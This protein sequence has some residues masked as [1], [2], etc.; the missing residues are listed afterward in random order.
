MC[1]RCF[2]KKKVSACCQTERSFILWQLPCKWH[3]RTLLSLMMIVCIDYLW[4]DNWTIFIYISDG[5]TTYDDVHYCGKCKL[6]F[7]N[8]KDYLE[9]KV[10]HDSCQVTYTRSAK[11][12]RKFL[13]NVVPKKNVTSKPDVSSTQTSHEK[14]PVQKRGMCEDMKNKVI[15]GQSFTLQWMT[16]KSL[17]FLSKYQS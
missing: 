12:R 6:V 1:T 11:D 8:I 3:V 17:Y 16:F 10:S 14:K 15:I 4:N 7:S 5:G 9:H 13:P 2:N